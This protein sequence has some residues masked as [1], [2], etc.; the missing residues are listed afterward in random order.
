MLQ[1]YSMEI[2]VI[3]NNNLVYR[4]F[5]PMFISEIKF[6]DVEKEYDWNNISEL[7]EENKNV[8]KNF[9]LLNT[10]KGKKLC[11]YDCCHFKNFTLA[12][13]KDNLKFKLVSKYIKR[14]PSLEEIL[15][16]PDGDVAIKYLVERGMNCITVDD[17]MIEV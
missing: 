15:K 1:P 17:C 7:F 4:T 14:N 13:W 8:Y 10:K 12:E 5:T 16:Y 2:T 9:K 11:I 3:V 6:I